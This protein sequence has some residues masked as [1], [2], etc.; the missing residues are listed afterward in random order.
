MIYGCTVFTWFTLTT[1]RPFISCH[2]S[3]F[4]LCSYNYYYGANNSA[5]MIKIWE[6]PSTVHH[7]PILKMSNLV[8][9]FSTRTHVKM[10]RV[11]FCLFLVTSTYWYWVRL[12]N[13]Q[14]LYV[15]RHYMKYLQWNPKRDCK[16]G[17]KIGSRLPTTISWLIN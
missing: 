15:L 7:C 5:G 4:R 10:I 13:F 6:F 11:F 9:L 14:N 2:L 17:W 3:I 8:L 1:L 12:Y 16:N